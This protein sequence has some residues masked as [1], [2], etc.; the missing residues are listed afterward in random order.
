MRAGDPHVLARKMYEG[1]YFEGRDPTPSTPLTPEDKEAIVRK[2]GDGLA[3]RLRDINDVLGAPS[4][5]PDGGV[6]GWPIIVIAGVA[7]VALLAG[8]R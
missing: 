6:S 2:Y 1:K 7:L 8:K 5:P 3:A 4:T